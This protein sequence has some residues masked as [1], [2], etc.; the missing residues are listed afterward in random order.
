M[1]NFRTV[2]KWTALAVVAYMLTGCATRTVVVPKK[3]VH[4]T[5]HQT[6]HVVYHVKQKNRHCVRH[7]GHWDC[8]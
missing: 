6:A 4:V 2:M 7:N 8:R 3:H 1:I 5:H